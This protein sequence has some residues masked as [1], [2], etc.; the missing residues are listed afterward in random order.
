MKHL[1][2]GLCF[3]IQNEK[4]YLI[5]KKMDII[6][7]ILFQ[8]YLPLDIIRFIDTFVYEDLNDNNFKDVVKLWFL[9]ENSQKCEFFWV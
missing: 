8:K 7:M 5:N 9:N 4:K 3:T 1:I 2:L 6:T